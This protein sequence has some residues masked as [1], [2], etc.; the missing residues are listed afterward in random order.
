MSFISW[1]FALFLP[2]VFALYWRLPHRG[3]ILLLFAASYLF[4][5]WWDARFLA[6]LL[7]STCTDFFCAQAI[8]GVRVPLVR[9]FGTCALPFLWL[10]LYRIV[11]P[12]GAIISHAALLAAALF[13]LGFTALHAALGERPA[14]TRSRA[15]LMLSLVINLGLLG[16]FKYFNFFTDSAAE[17]LRSV[18]VE[19]GWTLMHIIL[20]VGISFYTFQ[21]L[22]YTV[23]VYRGRM[24][25]ADD[26]ITYATYLAFFPQLVAGPI[27]R[28]V[29]LLPQLQKPVVW[30]TPMFHRGLRLI[31]VGLFKKVFVAD[32]CALLAGHAFN[33]ETQLNGPWA[34][35]GVVAFAFQ[36]Y[37][38][39][40]GYS[41]IAR[42]S[43]RV[44]GIHL[45][46]N[47]HFPYFAR[48]PSDFWQ[49]WHITLSSWFRDYVYIPLGGNRGGTASTLRN[50]VLT[51]GL[52][53]LWH[54]ASWTFVIWGLYHG[55]LLVLYRVVA[56]LRH[57][58]QPGDGGRMKAT[59]AMGLMFAFTLVG[60]AIFSSTS[61]AHLGGWFAAL[62]SWSPAAVQEVALPSCWLLLH[63]AP[64]LLLQWATWQSRD[65]VE[66]AHWHWAARG[67]VYGLLFL[68][69]ATS[70]VQDVVF[71]YFQF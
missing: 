62:M 71:I 35:L 33:P 46:H 27:E 21:T 54:G 40:S 19:P 26:F 70:S 22:S 68:T 64:L 38:D 8:A 10:T 45:S 56:P 7:V 31:L 59:L 15:F 17:V 16:F 23:D 47:F 51:M 39:F 18:G 66:M 69:V 57:L 37:G 11:W 67:V 60:W 50:L 5:G 61:L 41:D 28:S 36:I 52:A 58:E 2:L 1:E 55:A 20:P 65:E 3:R 48:G 49:R 34:L 53:G 42:G 24:K 63:A 6:L 14:A 29:D 32:N 25:P 9:V 43:A 13:P 4:Y 44:L 12:D 30:E